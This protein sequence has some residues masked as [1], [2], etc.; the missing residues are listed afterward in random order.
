MKLPIRVFI[1]EDQP[2]VRRGV[3]AIL[4]EAEGIEAVGAADDGAEALVATGRLRPDIVLLDLQR[5][6]A[7]ETIRTLLTHYREVRIVAL[8]DGDADARA[9][10]AVEAGVYGYVPR[11]G[12]AS[13]LIRSIRQVHSGDP[14]LPSAGMRGLVARLHSQHGEA[15]PA[16]PLSP[17]EAE[18]LTLVARGLSN[19]EIAVRLSIA[20]VT[21]RTHV[22]HILDK[23]GAANRVAA[24]LHALRMGEAPLDPRGGR[25]RT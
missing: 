9:L 8:S 21:V 2:L 13:E 11:S 25:R 14:A 20:E 19:R 18:V 12:P 7:F 22:S 5:T 24:A 3:M 1:V 4:E 10:A 15:E 17:R 6:D 16:E 23:L